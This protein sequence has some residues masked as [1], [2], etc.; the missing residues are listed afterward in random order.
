MGFI[1]FTSEWDNPEKENWT[2][3]VFELTQ[4]ASIQTPQMNADFLF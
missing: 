2:Q 3:I 4:D 1:N